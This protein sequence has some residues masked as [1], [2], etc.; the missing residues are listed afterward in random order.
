MVDM[1]I[2]SAISLSFIHHM[3]Y[4]TMVCIKEGAQSYRLGYIYE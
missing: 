3:W 4:Y 1:F 2:V